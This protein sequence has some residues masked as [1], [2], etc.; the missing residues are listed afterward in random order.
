MTSDLAADYRFCERVAKRR[1][2][3]FY[4]S[5]RLLP[6]DRRRSMCALYAFMRRVDDLADDPETPPGLRRRGL[7]GLRG[8]L[9]AVLGNES[10]RW[11]GSLALADT[12]RRHAIP[13]RYLHEV[14][15][16][17]STDLEPRTFA[18]FEDLRG[19]CYQVATAVGLCCLHIWGFTSDGGRAERLADACGVALQLTNILRDVPEDARNGRV[20]LPAD[21]LRRFGVDPATLAGP[22]LTPA[23]RD[24]LAFEAARAAGEYDEAAALAPLVSP[25]GR[26]VLHAIAGVYRALLDEIVK[27]D[28]DVFAERVSV[29]AWR[30]AAITVRALAGRF[31]PTAR[32]GPGVEAGPPS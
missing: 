7:D 25:V 26:P 24:L 9:D 27:R 14:I 8:E 11:P 23:L 17:V 16:G 1:A 5:F 3:N 4:P 32:G 22:E 6:A 29:P 15:G 10:A 30:K 20:Y 19:Y 31:T 2:R 28:Y 12:V 18:T 21:D 13:P